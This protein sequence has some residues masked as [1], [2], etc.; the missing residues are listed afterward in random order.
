MTT[1]STPTDPPSTKPAIFATQAAAEIEDNFE[2][3]ENLKPKKLSRF[4]M[5]KK[6]RFEEEELARKMYLSYHQ[7]TNDKKNN[8]EIIKE[9]CVLPVNRS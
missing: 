9:R 7:K 1:V 3:N 6:K 5:L 8:F 2:R 4:E